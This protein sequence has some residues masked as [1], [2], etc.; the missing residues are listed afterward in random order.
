MLPTLATL[1]HLPDLALSLVSGIDDLPIGALERG[2]QWTHSTDLVDPTPFLVDDQVLLTTGTQFGDS[3]TDA[4]AYV[5][6]LVDRGV[7]GLGF[8]TEV[9]RAG[10]PASLVDACR[11]YGLPLFEVPYRVPFIAIARAT[12]DLIAEDAYARH[13]WALDA[14]RAISLAALRPDGL[15]AALAELARSLGHG[16]ALFDAAG[17][18]DRVFP[19]D[20]ID[21]SA[22]RGVRQ[23]AT[24]L[25]TR[26]TRA[27]ATSVA[28]DDTITLHTLGR[29]GR[30]RGVLAVG[31]GNTL[32]QSAREV[33]ASVV[34]LASLALEQNHELDASRSR[35]RTG[36]LRLLLAGEVELA[37]TTG[38]ELWGGM[39]SGDVRIAA[40]AVDTDRR[41]ALEE[42]L[43]S[44]TGRNAAELFF[45][46]VDGELLA[47]AGAGA[48]PLLRRL[49]TTFDAR[50][51]LS[52][53]G[54]LS[55]SPRLVAQAQRALAAAS[56]AEAPTG[57]VVDFEAIAASGV[58]ASLGATDAAEIARAALAPLTSHDAENGT[59]L[60]ATLRA[61]L[62]NDAQFDAAA[63]ALGVHR[64]TVRN[65]VGAA[66]RVLGRDLSSFPA[67]A[68]LWAALVASR[69]S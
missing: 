24:L 48:L 67:R 65:R 50:I 57:S 41:G 33:V 11:R 23:D 1:L 49:A 36:L 20:A 12:A 47:V 51:G 14:Q 9:V 39:P 7:V 5:A 42:V 45:G 31:G 53:T 17:A 44:E 40:I 21:P 54:G 28:G 25:L 30:L 55:E 63:Q 29:R 3:P 38:T 8:G 4:D 35:L 34:G 32:D 66:E 13:S 64:H 16:V 62:E 15:R 59:A 27:S 52:G 46:A 10:T 68:E 61:W 26:G 22:L 19:A 2:V 6:R 58:L 69:A 37:T 60:V 43:E 18:V 56:G